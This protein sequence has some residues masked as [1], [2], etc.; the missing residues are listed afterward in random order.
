MLSSTSLLRRLIILN[1]LLEKF[2]SMKTRFADLNDSEPRPATQLRMATPP[3][4]ATASLASDA[5]AA[6][7]SGQDMNEFETARM[8]KTLLANLDG[9][10]YRCR[11]DV[12][13]T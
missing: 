12:S 3:R 1:A 5:E 4:L 6:L 10:V 13:W 2:D 11:D 8:L 7:L 9:M